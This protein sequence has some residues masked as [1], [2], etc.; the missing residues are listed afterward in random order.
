MSQNKFVNL[1]KNLIP[2]SV[3]SVTA[4]LEMKFVK[5]TKKI[6]PS[7]VKS[8]TAVLETFGWINISQRP[9]QRVCCYVRHFLLL[10]YIAVHFYNSTMTR[11]VRYLPEFFQM[12]I[13]DATA[14]SVFTTVQVLYHYTANLSTLIASIDTFSQA[15]RNLLRKCQKKSKMITL[16]FMMGVIVIG[17]VDVLNTIFPMTEEEVSMMTYIYNEEL[18]TET[19]D[20]RADTH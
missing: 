2:S 3:K 14:M 17:T 15:D 16:V 5:L 8:L 11:A 19:D 18:R 20:K 6:I 13:E 10:L 7:S 12:L 1:T 9:A 4:V